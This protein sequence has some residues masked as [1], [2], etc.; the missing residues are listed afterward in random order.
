MRLYLTMITAV[1]NQQQLDVDC[2]YTKKL[3][4]GFP[5]YWARSMS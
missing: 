1:W 5:Q 4:T 3:H 2:E